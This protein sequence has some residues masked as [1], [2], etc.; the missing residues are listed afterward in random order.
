MT[1][2]AV[3]DFSYHLQQKRNKQA[4][5]ERIDSAGWVVMDDVRSTESEACVYLIDSKEVGIVLFGCNRSDFSTPGSS[6]IIHWGQ[7]VLAWDVI[8]D[9]GMPCD[10]TH[11]K[12]TMRFVLRSLPGVDQWETFYEK[13]FDLKEDHRAH[14][15]VVID[16]KNLDA[17]LDLIVAHSISPVMNPESLQAILDSYCD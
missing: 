5:K 10:D 16:R 9:P 2:K 8:A 3:V 14:I 6:D 17:P 13:A 1:G 12:N 7:F 15:L 11:I 4:L